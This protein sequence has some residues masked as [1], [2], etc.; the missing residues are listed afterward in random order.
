LSRT[1]S[2]HTGS[3]ARRQGWMEEKIDIIRKLEEHAKGTKN[4]TKA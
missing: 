1:R 4:A 3:N 2:L